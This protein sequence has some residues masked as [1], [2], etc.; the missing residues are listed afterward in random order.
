MSDIWNE[1]TYWTNHLGDL[2][3][4]EPVQFTDLLIP[5]GCHWCMWW[6]SEYYGQWICEFVPGNVRPNHNEDWLKGWEQI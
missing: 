2:R 1:T 3:I 6:Y 5:S 4:L